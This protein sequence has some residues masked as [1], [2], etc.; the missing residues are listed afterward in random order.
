MFLLTVLHR[1]IYRRKVEKWSKSDN[2]TNAR[3]YTYGM[4]CTG[5]VRDQGARGTRF[6]SRGTA[7]FLVESVENE[8]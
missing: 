8:M 7:P 4:V 1:T 2:I 3:L 6:D 5:V